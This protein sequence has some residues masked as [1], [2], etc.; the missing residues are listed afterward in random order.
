MDYMV[1]DCLMASY[2]NLPRRVMRMSAAFIALAHV[3]VSAQTIT[4][5]GYSDGIKDRSDK[6]E[7][8]LDAKW[9]ALEKA[10]IRIAQPDTAD[11]LLSLEGI[12][13]DRAREVLDF[14]IFDQ[15]YQDDGRYKVTLVA[16]YRRTAA[17]N[18]QILNEFAAAERSFDAGFFMAANK[19]FE[20]FI[21][22]YPLHPLVER[23]RYRNWQCMFVMGGDDQDA[24]YVKNIS[25]YL[26]KY[27]Q[28]SPFLDS[29]KSFAAQ[30]IKER[31]KV[32]ADL[33]Y[34]K[35]REGFGKGFFADAKAHF[36]TAIQI[37]S[38]DADYYFYLG[39]CYDTLGADKES[40]RNAVESYRKA[41]LV[42]EST[43]GFSKK[44]LA[45]F[46]FNIARGPIYKTAIENVQKAISLDPSNAAY[47]QGLQTMQ[48][49]YKLY[50]Q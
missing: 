15:G 27:Y 46:Y 42:A 2:G 4:V 28:S 11:Y 29:M 45:V 23:A 3:M 25:D 20:D 48:K 41:I 44:K 35:G 5:E 8:V 14:R 43:P 33:Y 10:G 36:L 37:D 40:S 13:D 6:R 30:K 18:T 39:L 38:I 22:N 1:K 17:T 16:D 24:D 47:R 32:R 34:R 31:E 12:I 49:S 19:G 7:A 21:M 50:G 26:G 9:R